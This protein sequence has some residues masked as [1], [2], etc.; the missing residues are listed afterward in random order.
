MKSE[1]GKDLYAVAFRTAH[2]VWSR[3]KARHVTQWKADIEYLHATSQHE[4]RFLFTAGNSADILKRRIKIVAVGLAINF[5][6]E[7]K[8][9]MILSAS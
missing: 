9:G 7:D 1:T 3:K 4:A 8:Q 5:F 6:V 2:K